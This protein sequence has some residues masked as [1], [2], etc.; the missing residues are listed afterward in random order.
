MASLIESNPLVSVIMPTFNNAALIGETI[1]SV[2]AQAYQNLEIII[3]NDGS[4]DNTEDVVKELMEIDSRVRYKKIE[5][6]YSSIARNVGFGLARGEYVCVIDSDDL[7]PENKIELQLEALTENPDAVIIGSVQR[8]TED[9]EGDKRFGTI[10]HPPP[11]KNDY[12]HNLL[13]MDHNQMVNLNTLCAKRSIICTDGLWDP[14]IHT[15]H[16]WEVWIRLA[17]KYTF[18]HL[19]E[20]LQHYRKHLASVTGREKWEFGLKCQLLVVDRHSPRGIK[21]IWKKLNYRRIRY[22]CYIDILLYDSR[23]GSATKLWLRSALRSNML[24]SLS[25]LKLL[26]EIVDKGIRRQLVPGAPKNV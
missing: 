11:L 1:N 16:D 17:K 5:N 4:T 10:S 23:F 24:I 14:D 25:G 13:S 12:V 6:S 2:R 20:I 7:W 9:S 3:V 19:D 26:A 15:A 22:K 21:N 8:F 18:I